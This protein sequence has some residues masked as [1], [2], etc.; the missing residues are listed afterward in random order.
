[1][2]DAYGDKAERYDE[3]WTINSM[4]S[5]LQCDR[6]F[7]MDDLRVQE[8]RAEADPEG[9]IGPMLKYFKKTSTPV[10]TSRAYPDYP[11]TVAFPL[12]D[13]V[14][15]LGTFYFTST[16]AYAVALAIYEGWEEISLYGMDYTWPNSEMAEEG[17]G[18]V[19]YWLGQAMAR[20][21]VPYLG[22]SSTLL[23][24]Y[25]EPQQRLYG[26]DSQKLTQIATENG[27]IKFTWE[28]APLPT[29][30][31]MEK[32]YDKLKPLDGVGP[33]SCGPDKLTPLAGVAINGS[34]GV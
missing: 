16:P 21:I 33:P 34:G 11:T 29:A 6:I 28:D 13:V 18:C 14:S 30:E 10:Y 1:M 24:M 17:R 2:A 12:E 19:E 32:R 8:L 20:G 27:R 5:V 15:K 23:S 26:Y 3:V 31:A 7:H 4:G 9:K 22:S 25:K